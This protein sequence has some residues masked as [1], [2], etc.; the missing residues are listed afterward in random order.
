MT[1]AFLQKPICLTV[2]IMNVQVENLPNC[3]TTLRV[4]VPSEK[5]NQTWESIAGDYARHARLPG[6]RV[7]KAPRT[8]VEKKFQ[9]EIR[10]E[11]QKKLLSES[12]REAI[13][14]QKLRV[15]SVAEVEDVEIAPDKTMRFTATLITAP[16]FELP[17]YKAITV[18]LKS[19]EVTDA[20]IDESIENIRS[21]SADFVD[22]TDRELQIDDFAVIDY[23]ATVNGKPYLEVFPNGKKHL[24]GNKDF[25]I[26][27]STDAFFPGFTEQLVGSKIG[28]TRT[29]EL[30][31]P[32]DFSEEELVGQKLGFTVTLNL[33]KQKILPE[34]NDEF[35]T[36]IIPGKTL[37]ELRDLAKSELQ[38]QKESVWERSKRDQVMTY[39]LSNVECELPQELVRHETKRLLSEIV[40]ENQT[41]GVTDEILKEH[42]KEILGT[43]SEGARD[44]LKGTFILIRI[45]E[46]EKITVTRAEF[47]QR[48]EEMARQYRMSAEKLQK[49]LDKNDALDQVAEEIL[50]AKTLDF[51][52][53]NVNVQP[54][55]SPTV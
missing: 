24:A 1:L 34:L 7:G 53:S 40:R 46:E 50:S 10:E 54:V 47:K 5:V 42:E 9:K 35:A 23:S 45:A 11:L 51:L 33:I 22:L 17:D 29:F 26:K 48:M 12:C 20:E 16:T 15:I 14:E 13:S 31:T 27:L 28:E 2:R 4:E 8:I 44:R 55:A 52:V 18:E 3:I 19:T 30:E 49:E 21:Q 43:A 39:L 25:W 32:A 38:R 41:R 37:A 36:K 6:Y